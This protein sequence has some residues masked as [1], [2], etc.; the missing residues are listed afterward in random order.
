MVCA[1]LARE[2]GFDVLALTVDYNQRHRVEIEA[3]RQDRR[4]ARRPAHRPAARPSGVRR[5]GADQRYRGAEGRRAAGNPGHLRPRAQPRLPQPRA[6]PGRRRKARATSSSASTRSIIPAIRIAGPNS[7]PASSDWRGSRPR[8]EPR[9]SDFTIHAPLQH[10][11]KADIAREAHR[12][13]LDAATQPQLLRS[14][15]GRQPLRPVRRLPASRQGLRRGGAAR[16]DRLCGARGRRRM[17]YAVKECFLTLQGE[18]VQSGSRAVFL[19]FAGCNLWSGRE[20]DRAAAQCNF[21]DTDFVGTDG[22]G[23]GKFADADAA[24]R[25]RARDLWGEGEDRPARRD[26]RRGADASARSAPWSMRCTTADFASPS[27]ATGRFRRSAGID[28]L[29]ISPKAGTE[30]VQRERRRA[31]AGLAAG[32]YRS[33]RRWSGGTF[34]TS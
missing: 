16:S 2:Q 30:V 26:H 23:G 25:S 5:L 12:L 29:C 14:A 11:T 19:R 15:A 27:K 7:S 22:E 32:G 28:W 31:E 10:M 6:R 20:Q 4:G 3:A 8:R 18:G 24:G 1:A 17:T 9:A 34:A 13:G 33:G 21:C